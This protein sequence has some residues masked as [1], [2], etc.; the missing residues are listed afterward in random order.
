VRVKKGAS[1]AVGAPSS[2]LLLTSY[3]PLLR[4]SLLPASD[5]RITVEAL[6]LA[7]AAL[8]PDMDIRGAANGGEEDI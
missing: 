3:F 6:A 4:A 2:F 1:G 8:R 5:S 7:A